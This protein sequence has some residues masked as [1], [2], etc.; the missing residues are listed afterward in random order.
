VTAADL[1]E[2]D[3]AVLHASVSRQPTREASEA[4]ASL[5][6]AFRDLLV[7]L[8]GPSLTEQLLRPVSAHTPN[9]SAEQDTIQ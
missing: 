1:P 9:G 3:W 8:I 2:N 7:S 6:I 4:C 5:F